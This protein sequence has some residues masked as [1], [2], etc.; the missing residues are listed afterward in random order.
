LTELMAAISLFRMARKLHHSLP[1]LSFTSISSYSSSSQILNPKTLARFP[2]TPPAVPVHPLHYLIS[3]LPSNS[4][5]LHRFLPRA[6]S[7]TSS[8]SS[9]VREK[10]G[11]EEVPTKL[12]QSW[13]DVYLPEKVRP[14][15]LLARLDKPIGTWLLAWPCMWYVLCLFFHHI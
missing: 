12:V 6:L 8:Y 13:V 4:K 7:L 9:G 1:S 3:P 5:I 2:I 11:E 14:Y 15:A 10:G